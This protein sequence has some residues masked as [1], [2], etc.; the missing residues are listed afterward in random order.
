MSSS[1]FCVSSF[2]EYNRLLARQTVPIHQIILSYS[3]TLQGKCFSIGQVR[4]R[5]W[6]WAP[7]LYQVAAEERERE[8]VSQ[9][10]GTHTLISCN[11]S[12]VCHLKCCWR[13]SV[14]GWH[15]CYTSRMGRVQPS[16]KWH[17]CCP[18]LPNF[19][20]IVCD[21]CKGLWERKVKRKHTVTFTLQAFLLLLE[22]DLQ[23]AVFKVLKIF[24]SQMIQHKPTIK[25]TRLDVHTSVFCQLPNLQWIWTRCICTSQQMV[26]L[27]ISSCRWKVNQKSLHPTQIFTRDQTES[28]TTRLH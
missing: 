20:V 24:V 15:Q 18:I 14:I 9:I 5:K 17:N 26:G 28:V 27:C 8:R 21:W 23:I 10:K 22:D 7:G 19:N 11:Q 1:Q 6:K 25:N 2:P 3:F 12:A 4:V 13:V 16:S